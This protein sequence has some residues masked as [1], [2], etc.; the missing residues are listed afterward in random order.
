MKA[1]LKL[2]Q[3]F[4]NSSSKQKSLLKEYSRSRLYS[5]FVKAK[6]LP[7]TTKP[8]FRRTSLI[9]S[10]T[11]LHDSFFFKHHFTEIELNFSIVNT[12]RT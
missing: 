2:N 11:S 3:L 5:V 10:A 12:N 4:R 9:F 1:K 7:D 8:K 6:N